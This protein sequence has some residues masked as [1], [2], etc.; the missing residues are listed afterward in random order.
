VV[1]KSSIQ[2][3]H[4][5]TNFNSITNSSKQNHK[6][7]PNHKT[8]SKEQDDKK[9]TTKPQHIDG[10]INSWTKQDSKNGQQN[11][12]KTTTQ[13]DNKSSANPAQSIVLEQVTARRCILPQWATPLRDW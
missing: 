6:P 11:E 9:R 7:N 10:H 8:I 3:K 5:S 4:K 13:I 1:D 12:S 2:I